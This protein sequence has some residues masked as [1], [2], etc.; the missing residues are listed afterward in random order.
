MNIYICIYIHVL[1]MLCNI[2]KRICIRVRRAFSRPR[3]RS[4]R[5]KAQVES[6]RESH[7]VLA[8][9]VVADNRC[10]MSL[11]YQSLWNDIV[12]LRNTRTA[13]INQASRRGACQVELIDPFVASIDSLDSRYER[14]TSNSR[15]NRQRSRK[16]SGWNFHLETNNA[17]KW[18][19]R[20]DKKSSRNKKK[21]GKEDKNECRSRTFKCKISFA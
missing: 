6:A 15:E 1:G 3:W 17:R 12:V 19:F 20:L 10:S 8:R 7:R 5:F 2:A 18:I 4:I 14:V 21:G 11:E 9:A 16:K 13:I